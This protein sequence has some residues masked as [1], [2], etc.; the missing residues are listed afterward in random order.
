MI[1]FKL[2]SFAFFLFF[3]LLLIHLA[4]SLSCQGVTKISEAV[5]DSSIESIHYLGDI[6]SDNDPLVVIVLTSEGTVWRSTDEGS[7]FNQVHMDKSV[8]ELIVGNN[9]DHV[10]LISSDGKYSM[11]SKDKGATWTP[12]EHPKPLYTFKVHPTQ[13]DWILAYG[14]SPG[15]DVSSSED[16]YLELWWSKTM[17]QSWKLGAIYIMYYGWGDAGVNDVPVETVYIVGWPEEDQHGDW[18][19]KLYNPTERNQL[20]LIRTSTLFRDEPAI[21]ARAAA[22]WLYSTDAQV[23]FLAIWNGQ[24]S[25]LQLFTSKDS[26]DSW[27]ETNFDAGSNL[28]ENRYTIVDVESNAF[29]I[30]VD[31]TDDHWGNLYVSNQ[32]DK[33][34]SLSLPY[35]VRARRGGVEFDHVADLHGIFLANAYDF[36]NDPYD[37]SRVSTKITYD[38]GGLWR[39]MEG[40]QED[41]PPQE[42]CHMNLRSKTSTYRS[43]F[44]STPSAI[45]ILLGT[46]NVGDYLEKRDEMVQTYISRDAGW[47]WTKILNTSAVFE[48]SNHGGL[49]L[50]ADNIHT[51]NKIMYSW[52]EGLSWEVCSLDREFDVTDIVTEPSKKSPKFLVYGQRYGSGYIAHFDFGQEKPDCQGWNN[53]GVPGSDYQYWSP[54]DMLNDDCL[55]GRRMD[56]VR[57]RRDRECINPLSYTPQSFVSKCPC[58]R[59]DYMCDDCFIESNDG[60]SCEFDE[61][62]CPDRD[63]FKPPEKCEGTWLKTKGYQLVPGTMCD[64]EEGEDL[65]PERVSCSPSP[66][67]VPSP[68]PIPGVLPV[69]PG[70]N[71]SPSGTTNSNSLPVVLI[72]ITILCLLGLLFGILIFLSSRSTSVRGFMGKVVPEK[73]LPAYKHPIRHASY[74]GLSVE[75]EDKGALLEASDYDSDAPVLD[76]EEAEK[77]EPEPETDSFNPRE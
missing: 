69:A 31:H 3:S 24:G 77:P 25:D 21:L 12:S 8:E 61:M 11:L 59:E 5:L 35:N 49:I 4:T 52:N 26:G 9:T 53:P 70:Y 48:V 16:C 45:G 33:A 20:S 57:R 67:T 56:Y 23:M 29:F 14:E 47:S 38:M 55:L 63:P 36:P 75:T 73:W 66:P 6:Q 42:S 39:K 41:C 18:T 32:A 72:I 71:P 40:P 44:Y 76:L 13:P 7:S 62:A 15:C 65:T 68:P 46:G 64:T 60:K 10:L 50:A 22:G 58:T 2:E 37:Y 51:T 19:P 1:A 17:G 28:E 30:N 27:L 54:S 34:F 43:G 74:T